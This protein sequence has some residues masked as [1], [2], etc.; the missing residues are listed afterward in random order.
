MLKNSKPKKTHKKYKAVKCDC[1]NKIDINLC[2]E[3][4]DYDYIGR[5]KDKISVYCDACGENHL[6]KL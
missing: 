1:G 4:E 2:L 5:D 6:V 3:L